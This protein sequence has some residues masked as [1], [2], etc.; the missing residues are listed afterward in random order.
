LADPAA[1]TPPLVAEPD[2][3]T[4]IKNLA[5]SGVATTFGRTVGVRAIGL[6][7]NILLARLLAPADFG[8]LALGLTVYTAFGTFASAGLGASLIRRPGRPTRTDLA[9]VFG[10]QLAL[11]LLGLATVVGLA[12]IFTAPSLTLAALFLCALPIQA[13]RTAS[14]IHMERRLEYKRLAIIDL[15]D[16]SFQALFAISL[17]L[18]GLGVYGVALAQPLGIVVGTIALLRWRVSPLQRP[19]FDRARARVLLG[20][21]AMF[22]ASDATNLTR[23]LALNWGTAVIAGTTVLGIWSFAARLAAIPSMA[24][25]ALGQVAYSAVPRL[26][27]AGGSAQGTVVPTLRLTTLAVGAPVAILAG[28][29]PL[30]VPLVLGSPWSAIADVLPLLCLGLLVA[31]PVSVAS[32]GY[33]FAHRRVR[34]IVG[35]QIAHSIVALG[36]AFALL[37]SLG[38]VAL[39]IAMCG[40]AVT[41]AA[42]LGSATL[43]GAGTGY[44]RSVGPLVVG[45]VA[46]GGASFAAARSLDPTWLM[47]GALSVATLAAYS[48]ALLAIAR[49]DSSRLLRLFASTL[50]R[51]TAAGS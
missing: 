25:G 5:V 34:R 3:A 14:L 28:C 36:L 15:I 23:D 47:L 44:L 51:R 46:I 49:E 10:A 31:G 17:V 13:L 30:F 38:V 39:G 48:L 24:I 1:P 11:S 26:H 16:C 43:K 50:P 35:A 37:P 40:A 45:T 8:E 6:L 4:T 22:G 32:V 12:A 20:D 7:L 41:D 27:A 18:G 21:G 33:L 29:S 2:D 9:T 42:V 19:R